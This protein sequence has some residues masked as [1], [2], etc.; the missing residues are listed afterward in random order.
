MQTADV[1]NKSWFQRLSWHFNRGD[2][3]DWVGGIPFFM[4]HLVGVLAIFTGISWAAV[5]MCVFM[6]YFRMFAITGVYHRYFSHRTYKTSR[7]FQFILAFWGA[8][9]AQQGP[10]WWAAHHR[11]HHKFSDLEQDVHS[12]KLRGFWWSHVG[13]I[14][15]KRYNATNEEVVKD[16]TKYPEIRWI[17]KYHGIAPFILA[18]SIFFFGV[19]LQHAAPGLGTNGLQMLAWGFFTSTTILYHGT[20]CINSLAHVIG[21]KRFETGDYSKN[22]LILSILTMGEGWHNNHHRYPYSERQGIYWWE[23]DM[24]HYILRVFSWFGL[25]WDIKVHPPEIFA[26][27]RGAAPVKLKEEIAAS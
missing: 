27:A 23:I 9:A 10:I 11:H 21:K 6:Y 19:F 3:M 25:V 7:F 4:V 2:E 12:A 8:S 5:A 26:E 24:S 15:S 22:S 17:G 18:A 20:F 13:W 16:L 1:K 14:L